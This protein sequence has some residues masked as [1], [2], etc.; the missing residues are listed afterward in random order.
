MAHYGWI[1]LISSRL[2]VQFPRKGLTTYGSLLLPYF[3]KELF[4]FVIS[5]IK[6]PIKFQ[7]DSDEE[8]LMTIQVL[9]LLFFD[10]NDDI[11]FMSA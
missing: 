9:T 4:V 8:Y 6:R 11:F 2:F 5:A 7:L 1:Y 3:P 10:K